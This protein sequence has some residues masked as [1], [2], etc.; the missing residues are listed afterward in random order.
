[1]LKRDT[2]LSETSISIQRDGLEDNL[3][4]QNIVFCKV[5]KTF[6]YFGVS[7]QSTSK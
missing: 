1:M 2:S 4:N 7:F 5:W 6:K 3:T